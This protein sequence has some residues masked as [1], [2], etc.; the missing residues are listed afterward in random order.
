[1]IQIPYVGHIA[2]DNHTF[3]AKTK[4]RTTTCKHALCEKRRVFSMN[5]TQQ[6]ASWHNENMISLQSWKAK[7]N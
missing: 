4:W 7:T 1:M 3:S 2:N 6:V 5:Q